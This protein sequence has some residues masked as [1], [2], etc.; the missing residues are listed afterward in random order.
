[1]IFSQW[2]SCSGV[3]LGR[4]SWPQ[5]SGVW[6]TFSSD[7]NARNK[8]RNATTGNKKRTNAVY[9]LPTSGWAVKNAVT[10]LS[11]VCSG[12]VRLS[13]SSVSFPSLS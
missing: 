8:M 10:P 9:Q 5:I 11:S 3:P 6:G 1:M 12:A 4:L 7:R 13:I 2:V